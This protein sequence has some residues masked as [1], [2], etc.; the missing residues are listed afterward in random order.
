[1]KRLLVLI[2]DDEKKYANLLARRLNLRG[3]QCDVCF[4][5]L[6][7]IP[8]FEKQPYGVVLLDLQLPD[9]Y[10]IE[11]LKRIKQRHPE[12]EVIVITGHGTDRDNRKCMSLGAYAFMNKPVDIEQLTEIIVGIGAESGNE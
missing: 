5:G 12:T 7:A 3:I 4:D 1:M 9:I 2:V 11:V 8:R 10:G 6:T